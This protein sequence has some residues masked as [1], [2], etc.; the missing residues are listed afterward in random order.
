MDIRLASSVH[1]MWLT[2]SG[3][4]RMMDLRFGL[5]KPLDGREF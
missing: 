2:K 5:E 3:R 4:E 1:Q